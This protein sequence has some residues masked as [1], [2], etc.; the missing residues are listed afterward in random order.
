MV[1]TQ[2]CL[3]ITIYAFYVGLDKTRSIE[4][5]QAALNL[6]EQ[7][8]DD[9][10]LA[11][12]LSVLIA[13]LNIHGEN[14]NKAIAERALKHAPLFPITNLPIMKAYEALATTNGMNS[15]WDK[16]L[17]Y[18]DLGLRVAEEMKDTIG[19]LTLSICLP[20]AIWN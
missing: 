6:A 12:C 11:R 20:S 10:W 18:S 17:Q 3:P 9:K 19:I 8:K 2:K 14:K 1:D 13:A 4:A 16:A 7:K 15:V 5:A